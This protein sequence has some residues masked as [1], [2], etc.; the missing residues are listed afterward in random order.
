MSESRNNSYYNHYR[1]SYSSESRTSSESRGDN[2]YYR[3]YRNSY[4]SESRVSN[5][6][7]SRFPSKSSFS[8]ES[9]FS[10]S[11]NTKPQKNSIDTIDNLIDKYKSGKIDRYELEKSIQ[12]ANK[13]DGGR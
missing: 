1:D 8:S 12:N 13:R 6:N 10:E 4:S 5:S 2:A 7:E 11:E 9:R 3:N